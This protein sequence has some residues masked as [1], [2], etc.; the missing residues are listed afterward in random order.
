MY[1]L[2]KVCLWDYDQDKWG[3]CF[4]PPQTWTPSF[5]GHCPAN[6]VQQIWISCIHGNKICVNHI[7]NS[8]YGLNNMKSILKWIFKKIAKYNGRQFF[9]CCYNIFYPPNWP[10][11]MT[12]VREKHVK[13]RNLYQLPVDTRNTAWMDWPLLYDLEV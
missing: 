1:I 13:K 5:P 9:S 4:K 11:H 3:K 12:H 10:S 2:A 6:K 8:F 7:I